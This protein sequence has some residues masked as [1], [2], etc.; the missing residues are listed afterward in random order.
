M[1]PSFAFFAHRSQFLPR[2]YSI[3]LRRVNKTMVQINNSFHWN[4]VAR[5]CEKNIAYIAAS[6]KRTFDFL[7]N[8]LNKPRNRDKKRK[9]GPDL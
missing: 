2:S 8:S 9:T 7:V 5:I 1:T 4:P 3:G 6:F